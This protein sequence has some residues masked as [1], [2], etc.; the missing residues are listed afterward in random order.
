MT[1]RSKE[2]DEA[3][4]FLD[5]VKGLRPL[6]H[7]IAELRTTQLATPAV[8]GQRG[9]VPADLDS[10]TDTSGADSFARS[11]VQTNVVRRLRRGQIPI[12][13]ELDLHGFTSREAEL[14]LRAFLL[15]AR[16][17][18][19]QRGV[20]IIHGRGHGSPNGK[21]VLKDKTRQWLR[22]YDAVLA[23]CPAES[24]RGGAGAVHVLLR[25]K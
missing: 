10:Q 4:L 11:G 17:P 22:E 3:Q 23:F 9:P 7:G 21:S 13:D 24:A 15:N 2:E 16:V 6:K 14:K 8:V 12:E 20:L 1:K 5:S 18:N 25:K 19:R